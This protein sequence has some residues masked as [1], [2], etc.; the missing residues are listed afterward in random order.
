MI[1]ELVNYVNHVPSLAQSKKRN[2][3]KEIADDA[4]GAETIKHLRAVR[5]AATLI[6]GNEPES[7]GLHPFVYFYGATGRFQP[8][9]LLAAIAFVQELEQQNKL[10]H[11]TQRRHDF[12]EFLM[13]H[14]H[15]TNQTARRYGSLQRGLPPTLTMYRVIL[16]GITLQQSDDAI[17]AALQ[18]ESQLRHLSPITDDERTQGVAFSRGT[19]NAVVIKEAME[20]EMRCGMCNARLHFKSINI[21]H[22]ERKEEGGLGTAENAQVTH[23]YCNSGYKE[24]LRARDRN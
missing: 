9:S 7:L 6:S 13:R 17:V 11:F 15:F 21:D 4:D 10:P 19:K 14:R 23:P 1:F 24:W 22:V 12:E 5:R 20:S 16:H 8:T 18:S 3:T 2:G